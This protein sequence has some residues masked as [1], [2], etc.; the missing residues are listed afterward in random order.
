MNLDEL[1][2]RV[3]EWCDIAMVRV[4]PERDGVTLPGQPNMV[5]WIIFPMSCDF[6]D[7]PIGAGIEIPQ[8]DFCLLSFELHKLNPEQLVH[9]LQNRFRCAVLSLWNLVTADLRRKNIE[10]WIKHDESN[11]VRQS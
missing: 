8:S 3:K 9:C 1:R 5:G 6:Y 7:A 2:K 4:K 11:D 10:A